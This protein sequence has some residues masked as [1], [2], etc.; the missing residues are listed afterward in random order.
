MKTAHCDM[1]KAH[2]AVFQPIGL[3]FS[4]LGCFS[5]QHLLKKTAQCF[6]KTAQCF[7][8]RKSLLGCF[9]AHWA[10]CSPTSLYENSPLSNRAHYY[11]DFALDS[12]QKIERAV[13]LIER[14]LRDTE[15]ALRNVNM[16]VHAMCTHYVS[17]CD[18]K[19]ALHNVH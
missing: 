3:F 8:K 7:K 18:M 4:P 11:S 13:R 2:W 16:Y 19:R 14:A 17:P 10:V 5:A 6:K 9:S 12:F 1:K 15:R